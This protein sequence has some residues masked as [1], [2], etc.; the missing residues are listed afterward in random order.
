MTIER[1]EDE[2]RYLEPDLKKG[3]TLDSRVLQ[4]PVR[5]LN[6]KP[7]I[8]VPPDEPVASVIRRMQR[9]RNGCALVVDKGRLVGI[10]TERD[11]LLKVALAGKPA[12]EMKVRDAMSP[13]P[14]SVTLDDTV[15]H[16]FHKM[17]S[18]AYRHVPLVDADGRPVGVLSQREAVNYLVG[19]FPAEAI[20]QPPRSVEQRPP[21]NRYGG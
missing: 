20:N 12:E 4:D 16:A 9:E 10:F 14:E 11:V 6:P 18:G 13:D 19:F 8:S 3:K 21:K 7:T 5:V 1:E 2:K 15:G 17:S